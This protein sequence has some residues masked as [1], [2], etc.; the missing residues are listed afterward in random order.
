VCA[1]QPKCADRSSGEDTA[2]A[3]ALLL[4]PLSDSALATTVRGGEVDGSEAL[5]GP[6]RAA[7][8]L[9]LL[10]GGGGGYLRSTIC[11]QG[12]VKFGAKKCSSRPKDSAKPV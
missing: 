1:P 5:L 12:S 4:G 6:R 2:L 8:G 9:G 11:A 3:L 7:L 10:G